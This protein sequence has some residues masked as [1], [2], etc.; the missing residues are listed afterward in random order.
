MSKTIKQ[1]VRYCE[2][3]QRS[4]TKCTSPAGLLKRLPIPDKVWEEIS[5]DFIEGLPPSN[6]RNTVW[7]IVD[8]L[9]KFSHFI[10]LKPPFTAKSLA[11]LFV[12][13]IYF[14]YGMPQVVVSDRDPHFTSAF[15]KEFW[16]L[17]GSKLNFRTA[18]HPG[19]EGQTEVTKRDL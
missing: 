8:R 15:W 1:F 13:C 7:V 10:A 2:I 3:C 12:D 18:F 16:Q 4:K 5:M 19:S 14:L 6:G 11:K 17:Q 9:T